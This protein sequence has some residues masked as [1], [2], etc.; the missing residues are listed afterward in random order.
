MGTRST[1]H[2]QVHIEEDG[3]ESVETILSLY[4]QY[5]GYVEGV[6]KQIYETLQNHPPHKKYKVKEGY[7]RAN[8]AED[9][10]LFYVLDNKP[11]D[12]T[13]DMYVTNEEDRQAFNYFIILNYFSGEIERVVIEDYAGEWLF[14]GDYP[15]FKEFIMNEGY[16]E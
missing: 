12:R 1:V 14:S 6:G 5:D 4:E 16:E 10:A 2:F 13:G 11:M 8:G 7:V 9:L 3:K 15:E